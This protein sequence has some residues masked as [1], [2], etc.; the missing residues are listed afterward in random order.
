MSHLAFREAALELEHDYVV[1]GSG[2]GGAAA[3]VTLARGG[4]SV[5]IVEAGAWR[6]PD[7]YPSSVFGAMRDLMEDWGG[8]VTLGRALWPVVQARTVGGTTVINSAICVRTPPD[9]FAQWQ[10]EHGISGLEQ[11]VYAAQDQLEREPGGRRGAAR[12]ARPLERAGDGRRAGAGLGRVA[13]HAAVREA[14]R[15][16]G[17]LPAGLPG[18]PQAEPQPELRARGAAAPGHGGPCAPVS[19]ITF[20]GTRAGAVTGR[21]VHPVTRKTGGAFTPSARHAVVVAA[22]VTHSP[23]LMRS[24][25]KLP[26]LGTLSRPPRHGNLRGL[27]PAGRHE[28]GRHPGLGVGRVSRAAGAQARD[29]GDST[30]AGGGAAL[31]RRR[32]ADGAAGAVPPPGDVVPRGARRVGGHGAALAVRQP[33]GGALPARPRRHGALASA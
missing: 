23:V 13:L 18:P 28:R 14:L 3:A 31:G 8:Q 33:A 29:P 7:D 20:E 24:G 26:A 15:G 27:R 6:D 21:F 12:L 1:V 11:R 25:L 32:A 17:P 10:R 4:A 9:I 19:R 30:R 5:C 22:S 16:L 2:A